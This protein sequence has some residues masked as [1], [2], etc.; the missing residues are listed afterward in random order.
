VCMNL[1]WADWREM[2][3]Y[4]SVN[5]HWTPHLLEIFVENRPKKTWIAK[6]THH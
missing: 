4:Q 2:Q 6:Q 3:S 1:N 5:C